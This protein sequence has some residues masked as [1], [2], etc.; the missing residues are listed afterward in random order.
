[1]FMKI[2]YI[3]TS[4][5]K[6]GPQKV[7]DG[8]INHL[9]DQ[10]YIISLFGSD[11]QELVKK[12]E[13]RSIHI[14]SFNYSKYTI[15]SLKNL[16]ETIDG[17]NPDVIHSHGF[18]PDYVASKLSYNTVTTLHNNMFEDYIYAF[19]KL[20]GQL[21]ITIHKHALNN[22]DKI[23]CCSKSIYDVMYKYYDNICYIQNG[24]DFKKQSIQKRKNIRKKYNISD[25]DIIYIY[26][27]VLTKRKNIT[28]LL[29]LFK[30]SAKK[31][32][33]LWILG[34]GE[35]YD[36]CLAYANNQI[37][38]FGYQTNVEEFLI[39]SDVYVSSSNSEG[40]SMSILE[41]IA[42]NNYLLLSDIPSHNEVIKMSKNYLGEIFNKNNF[43]TKKTK[44]SKY[45]KETKKIDKD[46][47]NYISAKR[48]AREYKDIYVK[49]V[50]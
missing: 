2:L 26:V 49:I 25:E 5:K 39:A 20:K 9:D 34:D 16:R 24:I 3:V 12:Y 13:K 40:L 18:W 7:L 46:I 19:G 8:I 10:I 32:E 31:N 37:K 21:M 22:I 50:R 14:I 30:S 41:A 15:W 17:I 27:G 23:V 45:L 6:G 28:T 47:L 4:I 36:N 1:M 44:V 35:E 43:K 42:F 29:E 33:Y 11:D 38:L 48:M